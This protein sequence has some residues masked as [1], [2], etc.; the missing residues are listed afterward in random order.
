MAVLSIVAKAGVTWLTKIASAKL[1]AANLC[2]LDLFG[3]L[4]FVLRA[5]MLI[6]CKSQWARRLNFKFGGENRRTLEAVP[7]REEKGWFA[8]LGEAEGEKA[9]STTNP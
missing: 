5:D 8:D 6:S 9:K 7:Q 4:S 3:V 1:E 2:N